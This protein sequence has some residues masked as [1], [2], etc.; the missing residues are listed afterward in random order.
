MDESN[1]LPVPV[2]SGPTVIPPVAAGPASASRPGR[3]RYAAFAI[4]IAILGW[5]IALIPPLVVVIALR[6]REIDPGTAAGNLS[7]VLGVGALFSLVANPLAGRFSDRTTSRIGMRKPWVFSGAAIGYVGIVVIAFAPSAPVVLLGWAIAQ[8]GMNFALAALIAL[9]PDQIAPERRGRTASFISLAQNLGGVLA[10]FFVQLFPAGLVQYLVPSLIGLVLMI[11][12][13]APIRDRVLAERRTEPFGLKALLGSFVFNPRKNP[14]LGW[15]WLTRFFMTTAQF[16]ATS[17]LTY[18]LISVFHVSDAQAPTL[19][20]EAILANAV[21]ILLIT[22][23]LGWLSD[24][25]RRRKLFV[26]ISSVVAAVGLLVIALATSIPAVLVGELILG[27]GAGAF[28]AV[29]LALIADVLPSD[30]TAAKDLGVANLAQSL[31]QSLLPVAAPGVIAA[32]G[33]PG[34][35]IGGAVAGV[36]GALSVTRVKKVR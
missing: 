12:A 25:L 10:T 23:V 35:F 1:P 30:E 36:V 32:F 5:S 21:G 28:F 9:L 16:T 24:R 13:V 3:S 4:P 27:A 33:Y 14:D 8:V 18:F 2:A 31:P 29:E 26:I 20:F 22:P 17:Y 34:L 15:A 6:L 19:V 11:A 7:L